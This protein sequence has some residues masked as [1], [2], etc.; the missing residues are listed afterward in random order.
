MTLNELAKEYKQTKSNAI[1]NKI[2]EVLSSEIKTKAQKIFYK[3]K[4]IKDKYEVEIFNKVTKKFVKAERVSTFK[5]CDTKKI[6]L[7]DVEQELYLLVMKLLENFDAEKP[8]ENYLNATIKNWRPDFIRTFNFVQGLNTVNESELPE[9]NDKE[10]T[11]DDIVIEQKEV[12]EIEDLFNNLTESEKKFIELK[13]LNLD[14]NQSQLAEIIGV[15]QQRVQQIL[16]S[17]KKKCNYHL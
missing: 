8:F 1:L 7:E 9:K 17:L 5:L 2:F 6:D 10:S 14:K 4:F 12:V 15:T 11:L 13:K 16:E 3:Q